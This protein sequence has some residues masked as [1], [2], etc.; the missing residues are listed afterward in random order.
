VFDIE[1][2]MIRTRRLAVLESGRARQAGTLDTERDYEIRFL[3]ADGTVSLM[4]VTHCVG[5]AHARETAVRMMRPEFARFEVWH[6]Q[7]C[8]A[9][10]P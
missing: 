10:G 7:T 4:F 1:Q 3:K 6:G 2:R 5:D 8:A 9:K